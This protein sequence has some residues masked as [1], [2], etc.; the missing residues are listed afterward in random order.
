MYK[1]KLTVLRNKLF[2]IIFAQISFILNSFTPRFFFQLIFEMWLKIGSN[3]LPTHRRGA[4]GIL[5]STIPFYFEIEI[6]ANRPI[7]WADGR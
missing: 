2:N 1:L 6:L 3:C 7:F 4:H 5:F